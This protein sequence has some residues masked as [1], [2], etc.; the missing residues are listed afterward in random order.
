M[1]FDLAEIA[2]KHGSR[3]IRIM[4]SRMTDYTLGLLIV[5][6]VL[7]LGARLDRRLSR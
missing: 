3:N 6:V 4:F 1:D 2:S 7:P 5:S